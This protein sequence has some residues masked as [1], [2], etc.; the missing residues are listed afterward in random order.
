MERKFLALCLIMALISQAYAGTISC[1]FTAPAVNTA[2]PNITTDLEVNPTTAASATYCV[3]SAFTPTASVA[4]DW[5]SSTLETGL[6]SNANLPSCLVASSAV[7][8]NQP[9][10]WLPSSKYQTLSAHDF[11]FNNVSDFNQF[12]TGN[13]IPSAVSQ[14]GSSYLDY[15]GNPFVDAANNNL[16][17]ADL[18]IYCKG[19]LGITSSNSA[20]SQS[21]QEY[22]G[23]SPSFAPITLASTGI[24]SF[25]PNFVLVGCLASGRTYMQGGCVENV[26]L[27]KSSSALNAAFNGPTQTI[28]V[29]N[30]F[31][32]SLSPSAQAPINA[33]PGSTASFSFSLNNGGNLNLSV[34]SIVLV[35]STFSNLHVTSPALPFIVPAA[36]SAAVSGTVTVPSASEIYNLVLSIKSNTT[37]P[38]C[39]N[40]GQLECDN[41]SL[42]AVQI[43]V[44]NSNQPDYAAS[45]ALVG[46]SPYAGESFTSTVTTSNIGT[47]AATAASNTN[48]TFPGNPQQRIAVA[49]LGAGASFPAPATFTCPSAAGAYSESAYADADNVIAESNEANNNVS[50][51]VTCYAKPTGC[52]LWFSGH[53]PSFSSPDSGTVVANCTAGGAPTLCPSL[54]WS[55]TAIGSVTLSPASTGRSVSPNVSLIVGAGVTPQTN[56]EVDASSSEAGVPLTCQPAL[57]NITPT[58]NGINVSCGFESHGQVFFPGESAWANASCTFAGSSITCPPLDWGTQGLTGASL[59]PATTSSAP[60]HSNFSVSASAIGPQDGNISVQCENASWCSSTCNVSVNIASKP[61]SMDCSLLNHSSQFAPG[62]WSAVQANC[63]DASSQATACPGLNWFTYSNPIAGASFNPNPTTASVLPKTNF[64]IL[65]TAP[66][67]QSGL[68]SANSTNPLVPGLT[69]SAAINASVVPIG[70]D[71][72]VS[73]IVFSPSFALL[74]QRVNV[75]VTIKN[76]GNRNATNATTTRLTWD[77]SCAPVPVQQSLPPLNAGD[78]FVQDLTTGFVCQCT[79]LGVNSVTVEA[80]ALREQ[81]ESDYSNNKLS[82]PYLCEIVTQM[83]CADFV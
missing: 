82:V 24:Y 9:I 46:S 67:N 34:Y 7:N 5:Y 44:T 27:Y 28:T 21:P 17:K 51:P 77:A 18:G 10:N 22:I 20:F 42:V 75:S 11:F 2:I 53:S 80:N 8:K 50:L 74:N 49:A 83:T 64:S 14:E 29:A 76:I 59:V 70:P 71:Y 19:T 15:L 73:Q 63:T 78:S 16:F 52:V 47:A 56:P 65:P 30:P 25:T 41:S 3:G 40:T 31:T 38:D 55:Q 39:T 72:V 69:C 13:S 12:I 32:C 37:T 79:V 1:Q 62:D 81:Y 43:N 36:G 26:I 54:S 57:F 33:S 48:V 45:I 4:S 60:F 23:S 58:P 35:G 66:I 6:D 68:I 61:V